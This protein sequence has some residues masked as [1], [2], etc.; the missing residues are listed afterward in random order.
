MCAMVVLHG[1]SF[2]QFDA[3]CTT[4]N[5]G[6]G[7]KESD[8]V[9]AR[10]RSVRLTH[11]PRTRIP[12]LRYTRLKYLSREGEKST[13]LVPKKCMTHRVVHR[14]THPAAAHGAAEPPR[15]LHTTPLY[16]LT[17]EHASLCRCVYCLPSL[18]KDR[19]RGGGT[20]G[21]QRSQTGRVGLGMTG[22][23]RSASYQWYAHEC[24]CRA[25]RR[26]LQVWGSRRQGRAEAWCKE[27]AQ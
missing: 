5:R 19:R 2:I 10:L 16:H 18:R 7:T 6:R 4:H 11:P 21:G 23:S 25:L 13:P 14:M 15:R 22:A 17:H 9:M 3:P 27:E 20:E 24:A 1:F 26:T 8:P 12:S